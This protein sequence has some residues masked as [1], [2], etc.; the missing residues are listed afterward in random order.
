MV[1]PPVSCL[2]IS[3]EQERGFRLRGDF[4]SSW[5]NAACGGVEP[6]SPELGQDPRES[7]AG[8]NLGW[9]KTG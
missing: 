5:Q 7:C 1:P 3:L 9:Q 6:L 2:G 4:K 8:G